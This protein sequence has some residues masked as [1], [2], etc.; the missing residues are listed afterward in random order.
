M[1][2]DP[3]R[4]PDGAEIEVLVRDPR[5]K[6]LCEGD[7]DKASPP[8]HYRHGADGSLLP[9]CDCCG[10]PLRVSS[11]K[12]YSADLANQT[13]RAVPDGATLFEDPICLYDVVSMKS[14]KV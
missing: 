2:W 11:R 5:C 8:A 1:T 9:V 13:M 6:G 7:R 10:E 14:L 3:D 4:K 12:D